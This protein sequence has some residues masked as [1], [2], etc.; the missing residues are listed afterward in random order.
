M[1]VV[2]VYSD[3]EGETHLAEMAVPLPAESAGSAAPSATQSARSP[4]SQY[5]FLRV[6][7]GGDLGWHRSYARM[8]VSYLA[9]EVEVEVSDG[10]VCRFGPGDVTIAE[11]TTGKGHRSRA[12][13]SGEA[14]MVIVELTG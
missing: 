3:A 7:P 1:K 9:G 13:S 2:R 10:G 6:P 8:L 5:F 14:V 12:V 11:D 4:A